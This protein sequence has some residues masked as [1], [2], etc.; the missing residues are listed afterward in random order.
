MFLRAA[1]FCFPY[2]KKN[3]GTRL[4]RSSGPNA[5]PILIPDFAPV[6]RDD[7]CVLKL[8]WEIEMDVGEPE[9]AKE[10][11]DE[12]EFRAE[13]FS[14]VKDVITAAYGSVIH[15]IHSRQA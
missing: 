3:C 11:E 12:L 4:I 14:R 6:D 7:E 8:V 15:L 1:A 13:R 10:A 2:R 9:A 5:A